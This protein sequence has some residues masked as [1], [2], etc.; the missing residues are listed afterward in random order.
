[1]TNLLDNALKFGDRAVIT[2]MTV[3]LRG[4]HSYQ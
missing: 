2:L 3:I 4:G 1:M